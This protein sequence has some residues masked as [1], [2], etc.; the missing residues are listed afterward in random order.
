M[1]RP[2]CRGCFSR[3][4]AEFVAFPWAKNF[5]ILEAILIREN[6]V[7]ETAHVAKQSSVGKDYIRPLSPSKLRSK[8]ILTYV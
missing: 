8:T 6:T 5:P 2:P 3:S 1:A 4:D 7:S